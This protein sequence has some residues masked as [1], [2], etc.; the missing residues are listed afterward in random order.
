MTCASAALSFCA[1]AAPAGPSRTAAGGPSPLP[2]HGFLCGDLMEH[3]GITG[4]NGKAG[5]VLPLFSGGKHF[6][7]ER[8]LDKPR[9]AA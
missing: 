1:G 8:P 2:A 5:R 3:Y 9:A 4:K 6:F 7:H